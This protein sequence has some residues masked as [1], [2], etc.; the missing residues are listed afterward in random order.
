M[1][2][3]IA[4]FVSVA[5]MSVTT[6]IIYDDIKGTVKTPIEHQEEMP[7]AIKQK[8]AI[9]DISKE[10][11]RRQGHCFVDWES[12]EVWAR[13]GPDVSYL[14]CS[15]DTVN[16]FKREIVRYFDEKLARVLP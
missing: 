9:A 14:R 10:F 13:L 11:K 2:W 8:K 12:G 3:P 7:V 16:R 6:L 4:T 15:I 5:I 1:N